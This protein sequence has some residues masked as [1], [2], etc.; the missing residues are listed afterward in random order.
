MSA[1]V[2]HAGDKPV[3]AKQF[4]TIGGVPVL[5][6]C[7][8]VFAGVERIS[9]ILVAVRATEMERVSALISRFGLETKVR[10]VEGGEHRQG[11][12]ANAMASLDCSEDDVCA[13][14]R[15]CSAADRCR[16]DR[17]HDRCDREAW[18]SHCRHAGSRYDQAGG[19]YSGWGDC[20]VDGCRGNG[21]FMRRLLRARGMDCSGGRL[22][23]LRRTS[24]RVR[25]NRV[26]WSEPGSSCG[27]FRG[28]RGTSRLRSRA[29]WSL[30]SFTCPREAHDEYEDWVWL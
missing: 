24:L 27:W 8:R 18:R 6:H 25:M 5:V 30:R 1:G 22:A 26:C 11:S 29:I 19:A 15:C 4:L 21:W 20:D 16:D 23:R 3:A 13:G 17:S 7:L 10:V 9:E 2:T 14:A 28:R 12:V